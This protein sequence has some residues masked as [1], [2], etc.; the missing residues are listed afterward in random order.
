MDPRERII[1]ILQV[2]SI[3]SA[4]AFAA[5][6]LFTDYKK[7]GKVTKYGRLAVIGIVLSAFFSLGTRWLQTDLA[8][9]QREKAKSDAERL[10]TETAR[11]RGI[12]ARNFAVQMQ[13]LQNLAQGLTDLQD[14]TRRL[15][16][17]MQASLR[18][19]ERIQST[20]SRSLSQTV[21]L[22]REQRT[23]TMMTLESIWQSANRIDGNGI[24]MVAFYTCEAAPGRPLPDL[25]PN[26]AMAS[27]RLY[28][29]GGEDERELLSFRQI[30]SEIDTEGEEAARVMSFERFLGPELRNLVSPDAWRGVELSVSLTSRYKGDI[31]ALAAAFGRPLRSPAEIDRDES[32][33]Y[34]PE[35]VLAVLPCESELYLIVNG[36]FIVEAEP[37]IVV[38][39]DAEARQIIT[40]STRN[41]RV[42]PEALPRATIGPYTASLLRRPQ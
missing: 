29:P 11:Q 20:V 9:D 31:S 25:F 22:G 36:H 3:L 2:A 13:E 19:Q 27:V 40:I 30:G 7:D 37:D 24:E 21:L 4:G 41:L 8:E 35:N 26:G 32:P 33:D 18:T 34:A 10:A 15:N 14:G 17:D 38:T 42:V 12:D 28:T 23:S 39:R 6:G 5:L 1:D 16:G